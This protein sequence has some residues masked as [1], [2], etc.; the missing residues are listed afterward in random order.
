MKRSF[1]KHNKSR[2][3]QIHWAGEILSTLYLGGK[4]RRN[5]Y[6]SINDDRETSQRMC[7]LMSDQCNHHIAWILPHP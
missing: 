1:K 6:F 2:T 4:K 7:S 3:C 5:K